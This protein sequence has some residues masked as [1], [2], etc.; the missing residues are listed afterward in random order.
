MLGFRI[1]YVA[2]FNTHIYSLATFVW[3]ATLDT[4]FV[5]TRATSF[6]VLQ[7]SVLLNTVCRRV[8]ASFRCFVIYV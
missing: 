1:F 5:M 3:R 2:V 4:T 6:L 8:L 7:L